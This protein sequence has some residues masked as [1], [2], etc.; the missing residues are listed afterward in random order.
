MSIK[1]AILGILS[2]K[3]STGYELKKLIEDSSFFYWSGN[4]NQIYK[5]LLQM[6]EE[7]LVTSEVIHQDSSPTKKK[8]SITEEGLKELKEWVSSTPEAP[9]MKKMFLVQLAW[10]D[11]LTDE[12]LEKLLT[13]YE[14]EIKNQLLMEQEKARRALYTPNRNQR[15]CMIWEMISDNLISSYRNELEWIHRVRKKLFHIQEKEVKDKMNY[16]VKEDYNKKYIEVVSMSNSLNNENDILDLI[17]LCWEH[18]ANLLLIHYEVFSEDF[19]N[20]KTKVAGNIIQK[21]INYNIKSAALIPEEIMNKGRFREMAL[22]TNK[23]NHFRM[24]ESKDEAETW[25]LS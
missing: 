22:E 23:G 9:E 14:V 25:L 4:N 10:S 8:Y 7:E 12:E 20:L 15:E 11:I 1:Y 2:W 21:L 19:F 24:Y 17:S 16:H 13:Q 18:E 3:A 5:A 6:Q